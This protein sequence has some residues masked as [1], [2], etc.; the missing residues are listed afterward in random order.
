MAC[1][2][3][4]GSSWIADL[5]F[6][7]HTFGNGDQPVFHLFTKMTYHKAISSIGPAHGGCNIPPV[8]DDGFATAIRGLGT[9]RRMRPHAFAIPAIGIMIFLI[10]SNVL[11][12][13]R[14]ALFGLFA[15]PTGSLPRCCQSSAPRSV[16]I[17]MVRFLPGY[18]G[19]S[20]YNQLRNAFTGLDG[21][22]LFA[23]VHDNDLDLAP[24]ICI[25]GTRTVQRW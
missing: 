10:L 21:E 13:Y 1:A 16:F 6:G 4:S 9:V 5:S 22:G 17:Q 7:T 8:F 14:S 20:G 15:G 2:V 18:A 3:P 23:E 24:V 12:R 11:Q 19:I 25:N